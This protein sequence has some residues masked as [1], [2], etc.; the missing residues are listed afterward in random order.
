MNKKQ[1]NVWFDITNTKGETERHS[2]IVEETDDIFEQILLYLDDEAS[3]V[4]VN[5]EC[6]FTFDNLDNERHNALVGWTDWKNND[7][8]NGGGFWTMWNYVYQNSNNEKLLKDMD[9][10]EKDGI[11]GYME[12][13]V[14][15]EFG[16]IGL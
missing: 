9:K 6:D 8:W 10:Y 15:T 4:F 7:K 14:F 13:E 2:I 11:A 1:F 3:G 16:K 5:K 12:F